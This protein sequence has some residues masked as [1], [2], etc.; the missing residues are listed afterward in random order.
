[1][2]IFASAQPTDKLI[3]DL[4]TQNSMHVE[5]NGH[6]AHIFISNNAGAPLFHYTVHR[7]GSPEILHWGQEPSM[8]EARSAVDEVLDSKT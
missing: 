7:I 6:A 5:R 8:A 2:T 3:G 4:T 1:M